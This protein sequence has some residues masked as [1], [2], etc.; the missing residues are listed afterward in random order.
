MSTR[1]LS[2]INLADKGLSALGV[3][4]KEL[5]EGGRP[6]SLPRRVGRQRW[7]M[8]WKRRTGFGGTPASTLRAGRWCSLQRRV[9]DQV[10]YGQ[11]IF[12]GQAQSFPLPL[13]MGWSDLTPS[14]MTSESRLPGDGSRR[15]R[16]R[17]QQHGVG[18]LPACMDAH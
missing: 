7:R 6:S 18:H 2:L 15:V 9:V 8:G 16:R 4:R 3:S 12:E 10:V 5:I 13:V 17:G 11:A 1:P 14:P